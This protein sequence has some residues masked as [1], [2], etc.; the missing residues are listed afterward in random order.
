M[1]IALTH[2]PQRCSRL[3]PKA[4]RLFWLTKTLNTGRVDYH[5]RETQRCRV[6]C[7]R[8][9]ATLWSLVQRYSVPQKTRKCGHRCLYWPTKRRARRLL[10]TYFNNA[11]RMKN[12]RDPRTMHCTET[13]L[14]SSDYTDSP[15]ARTSTLNRLYLWAASVCSDYS[16]EELKTKLITKCPINP[17]G[18]RALTKKRT[19]TKNAILLYTS[20]VLFPRVFSL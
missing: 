2:T 10:R 12:K 19:T 14:F 18:C 13:P 17:G 1:P 3:N 16:Q 20:F 4:A 8:F 7:S 15:P 9:D 5:S 6:S 11:A